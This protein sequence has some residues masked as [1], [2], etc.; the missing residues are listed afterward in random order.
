MANGERT[1][2]ATPL[3]YGAAILPESTFDPTQFG[4]Q[5]AAIE[6]K[7]KADDAAAKKKRK[8]DMFKTLNP[9][10]GKVKWMSLFQNVFRKDFDD[11]RKRNIKWYTEQGHKLTDIQQIENLIWT[12]N[13]NSKAA[14]VNAAW[15]RYSELKK[16]VETD[17]RFNTQENRD[18][19]DKYENFIENDPEGLKK[20]GGDPF[21]Y[22]ADNIPYI[23]P[24]QPKIDIPAEARK[25]AKE[26]TRTVPLAT[27]TDEHG[28]VIDTTST[29]VDPKVMRAT[30]KAIWDR[31]PSI[32]EEYPDA[33]DFEKHFLSYIPGATVDKKGTF[34][35]K[36]SK[37]LSINV[38]GYSATGGIKLAE[39]TKKFDLYPTRTEGKFWKKPT[40][41]KETVEIPYVA[42]ATKDGKAIEINGVTRNIGVLTADGYQYIPG[43]NVNL[44]MTGI[45]EMPT[46]TASID[47]KLIKDKKLRELFQGRAT[48]E[49]ILRDGMILL[50]EDIRLLEKYGLGENFTYKRYAL[51][52]I[53][54][55]REY[56]KEITDKRTKKVTKVIKHLGKKHVGNA[57]AIPL[58]DIEA[59][60]RNAGISYTEPETTGK[61]KVKGSDI[62]QETKKVVKD[63]VE[64]ERDAN[65]EFKPVRRV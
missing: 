22:I 28:R 24:K 60:V 51:G 55:I 63:G 6:Q 48:P 12:E 39:G 35:P 50:P 1:F 26:A 10:L 11:Y 20:A 13:Y 46:L 61:T 54:N 29:F 42:T 47:T 19:L 49:G 27:T 9:E 53:E 57:F 31:E 58:E 17:P 37:G 4:Q 23:T 15:A 38:G 40:K 45:A 41:R 62:P 44:L 34:I 2:G 56:Q 64:Y 30:A 43:G 59:E 33:D 5:V 21:Q 25:A 7:K 18:R 14:S 8:E 16:Q 52:E 32:Q 65:G 3:G 36:D